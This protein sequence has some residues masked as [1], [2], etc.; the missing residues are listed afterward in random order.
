MS[1]IQVSICPSHSAHLNRIPSSERL[2]SSQ[3]RT[4]IGSE[5]QTR[6][7][8]SNRTLYEY[9]TNG[10]DQSI[11]RIINLQCLDEALTT[12]PCPIIARTNRFV[13]AL[14]HPDILTFHLYDNSFT[15]LAS[16]RPCKRVRLCWILWCKVS[17]SSLHRIS[18]RNALANSWTTH[19]LDFK[20]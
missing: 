13:H 11:N 12:H 3:R 7:T 6:K 1:T 4:P 9:I 17:V 15:L 20:N 8:K 2:T 16:Q 19:L 5:A 14:H 10:C 18:N